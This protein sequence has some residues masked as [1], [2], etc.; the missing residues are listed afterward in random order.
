MAG[1]HLLAGDCFTMYTVHMWSDFCSPLMRH[2]AWRKQWLEEHSL[3]IHCQDLEVATT[4]KLK[5]QKS[6]KH[7]SARE[8]RNQNKISL[9][10]VEE[11]RLLLKGYGYFISIGMKTDVAGM[12]RVV[13][14]EIINWQIG[15]I[16]SLKTAFQS[17]AN[18]RIKY[19]VLK[20]TTIMYFFMWMSSWI[21]SDICT[22]LQ[23]ILIYIKNAILKSP[24]S[25]VL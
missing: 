25:A 16:Q 11:Q 20:K 21:F 14:I 2:S 15:T 23:I 24:H 19:Y 4:G 9:Q 3:I 10:A 12:P 17:F 6:L 1:A 13:G 8:E 22:G 7:R 5:A 18:H